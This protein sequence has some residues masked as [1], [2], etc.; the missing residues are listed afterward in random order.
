MGPVKSTNSTLKCSGFVIIYER[1]QKY[2]YKT[3]FTRKVFV[4]KKL[5]A[6]LWGRDNTNT[7]LPTLLNIAIANFVH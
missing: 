2:S 6:K 5:K 4:I 1:L 3:I 7:C